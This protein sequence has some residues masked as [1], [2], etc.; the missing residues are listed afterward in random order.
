VTYDREGAPKRGIV[1]GRIDSGER[2]V[3]N[4]A[5]DRALLEAMVSSEF[6]GVEGRVEVVD[7]VGRFAS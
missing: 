2:F 7:G 5:E 4:T 1:L 6:C 3:A